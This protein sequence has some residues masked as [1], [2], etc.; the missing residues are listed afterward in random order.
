V[1]RALPEPVTV[2]AIVAHLGGELQG[3]PAVPVRTLAT[4]AGAGPEAISFL[5]HRRHAA[6]ARTSRAGALIVAPA[7]ADA[8]APGASLI[9]TEDPYLYFARLA[10]WFDALTARPRAPGVDPSATV[11]ADAVLARGV[12]VCAGAVIESGATLSDGCDVGPGCVIGAGAKIGAGTRLHA[13]VTVYHDCD[14]GE[15]CIVH[16]G[17]VI[18]ADGFGFAPS[19]QGW[20]KIPQLG[21]V[22]IG[23]DVEIG[24]NCSI[25]RGALDDTVIES[26]CKIDNLVQ[27][28]HN[29]RIGAGTAIAGCVGIA[30]SA[31]IGRGCMIG[32]GAGIR[33]HIEICDGVTIM[34]MTLVSHS[35]SEPGT[36]TG[37]F[38]MTPHA[39]W[40]RTAAALKQLP[41]WR[42]TLRRLAAD[43]TDKE[44]R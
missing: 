20:L 2:S 7:L 34:G 44:D 37:V 28:A 17:T 18:G 6:A 12:R 22:R 39:Q 21:G 1:R 4:L 35:I 13:N 33:G 38:P 14:I 40:E 36:Y 15:R 43:R 23:D 10:Q 5:T 29:V 26:G 30:G 27:V 16:S 11:A 9:L 32:G 31:V 3:A 25:D 42:Q 19:A 8:A 41:Q 24:S